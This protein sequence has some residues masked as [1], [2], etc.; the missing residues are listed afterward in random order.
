VAQLRPEIDEIHNIGAELV[1]VGNGKPHFAKAFREE[2]KLTTP[3]FT[4]PEQNS[5]RAAGL[6]R[7]VW[8]TIGPHMLPKLFKQLAG[9][10]G[11]IKG[12]PWQ[13]G[14]VFIVLPNGEAPY[15]FFSGGAGDHP[16]IPDIIKALRSAVKKK[17]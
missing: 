12:D 10:Y 2:H 13:Q 17:A 9:N 3:L 1:V 7:S 4:D 6:K 15:T 5:Y 8:N 14:G 11:L 16:A